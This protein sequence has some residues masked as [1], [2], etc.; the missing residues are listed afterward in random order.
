M[1][2][3][4]E[5]EKKIPEKKR[6]EAWDNFILSILLIGIVPLLPILIE[7]AVTRKIGE[8]SLMITTAIY[9]VTIAISSNSKLTFGLFLVTSL[10]EVAIYGSVASSDSANL[11]YGEVIG[12]KI[13]SSSSMALSDNPFFM[14]AIAVPFL[15]FAWERYSR[16][17]RNREEVFEF[18]K[19]GGK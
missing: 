5:E 1:T 16:H 11:K 10:V 14:L 3:R 17:V 15:T 18:L 13:S 6:R 8:G 2:T 7:L 19:A 9:N 12:I 4:T